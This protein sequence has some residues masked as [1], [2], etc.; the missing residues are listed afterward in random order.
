MFIAYCAFFNACRV[1]DFH[2]ELEQE[3]IFSLFDFIK[4]V[5]SRFE[6]RGLPL[7]DPL[8]RS[9]IY[10]SGMLESSSDVGAFDPMKKRWDQLHFLNVPVF[11]RDYH[12]L[13]LPTFVPIGAPWQKI[14][15]LAR[16]HRKVYVE[17]FDI[18]PI[19]MT[20]RW[21]SYFHK[22]IISLCSVPSH[23]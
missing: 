15:L 20:L 17:V 18:G 2:L 12:N 13:S 10:D 22:D 16:R 23:V 9:L 4:N 1:A 8:V 3:L 5:S 21:V 6:S 14:Y 7:S 11:N 19:K